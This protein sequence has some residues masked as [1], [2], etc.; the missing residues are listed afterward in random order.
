V[1]TRER[2]LHGVPGAARLER[3]DEHA[4]RR[5]RDVRRPKVGGAAAGA[6]GEHT[7]AAPRRHARHAGR[8][9]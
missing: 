5:F 6:D 4:R 2:E 1:A 9:C 3:D 8:R 7:G